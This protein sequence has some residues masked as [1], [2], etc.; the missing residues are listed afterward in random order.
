MTTPIKPQPPPS[1]L[2]E[3]GSVDKPTLSLP[4]T[5]GPSGNIPSLTPFLLG[6]ER[7]NKDVEQLGKLLACSLVIS[8]LKAK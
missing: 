1:P 7:S 3:K 6:T 4:D 2:P 8:A 5:L